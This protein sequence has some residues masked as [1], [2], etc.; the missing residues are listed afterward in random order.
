MSRDTR[1]PIYN[2]RYL[3]EEYLSTDD[4]IWCEDEKLNAIKHKIMDRLND[5]EK[6]L[7]LLYAEIGSQRKV[8]ELLRVSPATINRI[9]KDIREKLNKEE[10]DIETND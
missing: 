2:I 8:A 5:T 10:R 6:R 9:I 1:R 4:T 7:L 3:E